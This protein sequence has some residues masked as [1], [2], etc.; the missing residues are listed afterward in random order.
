MPSTQAASRRHRREP[1][2]R[3]PATPPEAYRLRDLRREQD[4]ACR[5][6]DPTSDVFTRESQFPSLQTTACGSAQQPA[7]GRTSSSMIPTG[8]AVRSNSPRTITS[9]ATRQPPKSLGHSNCGHFPHAANAKFLAAAATL[10]AASTASAGTGHPSPSRCNPRSRGSAKR[11]SHFSH[12]HHR[13]QPVHAS[14][15]AAMH[16]LM[17]AQPCKAGRK[18]AISDQRF[19][20]NAAQHLRRSAAP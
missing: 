3:R 14:L 12:T 15:P 18:P 10:I 2:P 5:K 20:N 16:A 11:V 8:S 4:P 1:T 6:L 17:R 13:R 19:E 7:R 9:G